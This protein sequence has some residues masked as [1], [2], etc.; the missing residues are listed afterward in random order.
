MISNVFIGTKSVHSKRDLRLFSKSGHTRTSKICSNFIFFYCSDITTNLKSYNLSTTDVEDWK[1]TFPSY[2]I[3]PTVP[4]TFDEVYWK[5]YWPIVN[6]PVLAVREVMMK[7]EKERREN[8]M[9]KISENKPKL[10]I[11]EAERLEAQKKQEELRLRMRKKLLNHPLNHHY[12]AL[13][14]LPLRK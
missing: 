12:P 8:E 14:T 11:E 1:D 7:L 6:E 10:E 2:D 13:Q 9:K 3:F 4:L 5:A